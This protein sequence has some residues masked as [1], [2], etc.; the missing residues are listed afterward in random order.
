MQRAGMTVFTKDTAGLIESI[1][2]YHRPYDMVIAFSTDLA[3]RLA[4]KMTVDPFFGS[5]SGGI[6]YAVLRGQSFLVGRGAGGPPTLLGNGLESRRKLLRHVL[7]KG[8]R[9]RRHAAP[10]CIGQMDNAVRR[11]PS[12]QEVQQASGR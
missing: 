6:P 5:A 1:R 10:A 4:G 2:L 9:R 7:D 12:R 8:A 11:A 3:G